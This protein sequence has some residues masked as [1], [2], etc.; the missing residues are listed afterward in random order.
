MEHDF[1]I[2]V[3]GAV[4]KTM[5]TVLKIVSG[6][7]TGADRAALAWAIDRGLP[8]GGWCPA[9]RR[10]EDGRIPEN[11]RLEETAETGYRV[12]TARN[13]LDSDATVI[14]S[15][16]PVL[17][18]GSLLTREIAR[19]EGKPVLHLSRMKADGG[20]RELATVVGKLSEFVQ[21]EKVG[22][23]NVAGPRASNEPDI[24]EFVTEVL[25]ATK[26]GRNHG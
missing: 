18:G 14:F 10:A 8:H 19:R 23:L 6:G 16:A 15:I 13:V 21:R 20:R 11:Y 3:K 26:I 5:P 12:R 9:G 25:D 1:P 4:V 7:Q 2:A 22:V 24:G 17:E